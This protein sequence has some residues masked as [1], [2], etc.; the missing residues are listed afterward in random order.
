VNWPSP[1][2]AQGDTFQIDFNPNTAFY[3]VGPTL[4]RVGWNYFTL[5]TDTPGVATVDK[6][7]LITGG[8]TAGTALI[9][10]TY[11]D[12]ASPVAGNATVTGTGA[13]LAV[14][15]DIAPTPTLVQSGA[16]CPGGPDCSVISLFS[17]A[18]NPYTTAATGQPWEAK[19]VWQSTWSTCCNDMT[20][21]YLIGTHSVIKYK[22]RH[23]VGIEFNPSPSIPAD[24][25]PVIDGTNM[26]T[27]HV[28]VWTPN[29]P[30]E[31]QVQLVQ[32]PNGAA[33][34]G[35]YNAV[36]LTTGSWN[37]LEI[38]LTSFVPALTSKDK[39]GQILFLALTAAGAT[40][41]SVVYVDNIYFHQ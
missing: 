32:D 8:A 3:A 6:N 25:A 40:S 31:L 26:T 11:G 2:L 14:P 36:G 17:S 24:A 21:P 9:T 39:L 13:P 22:L 12:A 29:P 5:N 37:S 10:A 41:V 4:Y 34:I 19:I 1:T 23:F 20:N 7:G 15:T 38:P 16:G 18:Y 27:L 33:I 28:D 30:G 35:K